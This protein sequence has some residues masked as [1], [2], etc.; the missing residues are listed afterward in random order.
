MRR[1]G[2]IGTI[3][4]M[5]WATASSSAA[6][7]T[8]IDY[9]GKIDFAYLSFEKTATVTDGVLH[10]TGKD[11]KGGAGVIAGGDFA[12][13]GD[14]SPVLHLKVGPANK[15]GAVRLMLIDGENHRRLFT[16]PLADVGGE[17]FTAVCPEHAQALSPGEGDEL[18]DAADIR[19]VQIQGDWKGAAVDVQ[20]DAVTLEEPTQAMIQQ[21][22]KRAAQLK[23]KAEADRRQAE[24]QQRQLRE[25]LAHPAH[26]DDGPAIVRV[27]P[28]SPD[29]LALE[30]QAQVIVNHG[31]QPYEAKP[32]DE[33]RTGDRKLLVWDHGKIA[34]GPK[35]RTLFRAEGDGQ[36]QRF[37]EYTE[38]YGTWKPVIRRERTTGQPLTVMTAD[39][40]AA[41]RVGPADGGEPA[42]P[43]AVYRKSK[44]TDS[45]D[46]GGDKPYRHI[47]YLKL[48]SPLVE[49]Q[50]YT[51]Q[52][53]GLNTKQ[54]EVAYVHDPRGTRSEA[55]HASQIGYRPDDPYKRAYL[56]L[57]AGTGGGRTYDT[58]TFELIDN[59]T[60]RTVY[61]GQVKL[62]F[63]ASRPEQLKTEKNF[64]QAD[65]YDLDFSDF[66]TPG[67]Y[68]VFVP[69][70]G[71]SYPLT[72]G[73]DVWTEAF[74]TSMHGFLSHRSGIALGPPFSDYRRPRNM[75]P[76]DGF[77]IFEIIS[78][79]LEG[80]ASKVQAALAEALGPDL[81]ASKLQTRAGAW[82][83]YMDAGD[84]DRRSQHL[85][86]TY[87]HLELLDLF[88]AF[89]EAT[90]LA[91]PAA[92][93]DDKLP[94]VL[95]E[96]LWNIDLYRRLQR[97]DGGVGGGVEST[98]HPRSGEASWQETLLLG[99]FAPDPLSSMLYAAD[100]AKAARLMRKYDADRAAGYLD[101][102]AKAF[103]W[104]RRNGERVLDEVAARNP[105]WKL[106]N[107]ERDLESWT[108]LAAI[109]LY[110]ATGE[111]EY[112]RIAVASPAFT[113]ADD[114]SRHWRI[115]YAYARLPEGKGDAAIKA[116][117]LRE[118]GRLAD[119]AIAFA[120]GNAF[121][122]TTLAP[123]L[124]MMG[125]VGY[126]SVP[127]MT[128]GPLL[129]RMYALTGDAKYLR[130]ALVAANFSAGANP[131]NITF[132][133]GVGHD[134][135][136][137]PL[138][139][140]SRVTAQT[141]PVGITVYGPSDPAA[142]YSFNAWVHTWHLQA[143]TPGSRTWPAAE[144]YVDLYK[145]PAMNEY[146]V[147]QTMG[148]TSFYWGALAARAALDEDRP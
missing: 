78:T 147:Q 21:R 103:A 72:I 88:P 109:E 63:P 119:G 61:T 99:T 19:Q 6:G 39:V 53:P 98:A 71:C 77:R 44:P 80:E 48:A 36:P 126:Y 131:A 50:R 136:H 45:N 100:A 65:V 90:A 13:F 86:P 25:M 84:W 16:Y 92:E 96:A 133:T 116:R 24:E 91:L 122:L 46:L 104:A 135:P 34:W 40:P 111:A 93:A 37:A 137:A 145:W 124:P 20:I 73:E 89:C 11:G 142:D 23:A 9:S 114:I 42:E 22:Q 85:A 134:F 57:W 27:A 60:G 140:D 66:R 148:P 59:R 130:A 3:L 15:A 10:L 64:V 29:M 97:A 117:A 121:G 101:T 30:I 38:V 132:T 70:V 47:I 8:L 31:Q 56:S 2:V 74:R 81:D 75:H 52:L 5:A 18:F 67:E 107:T 1:L 125:Y 14:H 51:V 28:V 118:L 83:G 87:E 138:H 55:V 35:D 58:G 129:P 4:W 17:S 94:D 105:D 127:E 106:A 108:A 33:I 7:P 112:H 76:A 120:S 115:L 95:N 68:R 144:W 123:S 12:A 32:G 102:A 146:T 110:R 113:F 139:I 54:A 128:V 69:G 62:G 141:P 43:V 82:G 26:P 143:M 41:Y 79:R 49:G